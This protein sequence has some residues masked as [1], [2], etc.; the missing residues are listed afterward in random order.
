MHFIMNALDEE[1]T[2]IVW[3]KHFTFKPRQI[4]AMHNDEVAS[5]ILRERRELGFVEIPKM[6]TEEEGLVDKYDE[7]PEGKAL[8]EEKRKQGIEEY[9]SR[10]RRIVYNLQVSLKK[11]LAIKNM[12]IDPMQLASD[13]DVRHMEQLLKYQTKKEDALQTRIEKAKK[14][15]K[16]LEKA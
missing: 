5:F 11:D 16:L 9:C 10:L 14:L 4:K 6:S 3:G 7:S 2:I 1:Q 13:G 15:E 12:A 8:I